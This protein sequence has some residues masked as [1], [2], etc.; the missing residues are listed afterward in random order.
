MAQERPELSATPRPT[1]RKAILTALRRE[2]KIP[3]VVYGHG[4]PAAIALDAREITDFLRRHGASTLIDLTVN[5]DRTTA[6][7]KQVDHDPVSGHVAHLDL[8]RVSLSD[9]ITTHVP[10]AFAGVEEVEREGG[11]LT[12]QTSE[13]TV[14]CRADH[15]PES[16]HVDVGSLRPGD[17]IRV[18][19]LTIPEGVQVTQGPDQVVVTCTSGVVEAAEEEEEEAAPAPVAEAPAP[20]TA[21]GE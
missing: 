1:G 18:A 11:V 13:L 8:Q 5:G 7:F 20:E 12:Y 16:I 15:L 19:D 2:G 14:H 17:L 21:E 6:M 3:A 4:D 10:V 9:T